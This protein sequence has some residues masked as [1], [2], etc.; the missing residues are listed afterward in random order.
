MSLRHWSTKD[1]NLSSFQAELNLLID[2]TVPQ[3]TLVQVAETL[4]VK[5]SSMEFGW[6][7]D[8][9]INH[10]AQTRWGQENPLATAEIVKKLKEVALMELAGNLY[11]TPNSNRE[12]ANYLSALEVISFLGNSTKE[13]EVVFN[14]LDT[15][16][17][18]DIF[19]QA[20]ET[21]G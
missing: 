1:I 9:F 6:V 8:M 2:A 12:G 3:E 16:K 4:L 7:A 19:L 14:F 5:G 21:L 18:A 13:L 15:P 17:N 10:Q 11:F 20:V